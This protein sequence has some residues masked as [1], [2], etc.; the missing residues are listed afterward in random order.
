MVCR[1]LWNLQAL[2]HYDGPLFDKFSQIIIKNHDKMEELDVAN[3]FSAFS[4]FMTKLNKP[5]HEC[6][7][8]LIRITIRNAK[9]YNTQT[10]AVI[11]K[12]LADMDINNQ[13]VFTIIKNLLMQKEHEEEAKGQ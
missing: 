3:T 2:D 9:D 1:N 12:S 11:T 8:S 5:A 13:A 4:H 6:L 7:E 10:L